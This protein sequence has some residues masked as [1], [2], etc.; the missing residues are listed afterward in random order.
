LNIHGLVGEKEARKWLDGTQKQTVAS[1]SKV[2][3]PAKK[4]RTRT[5]A[6]AEAAGEEPEAG[7]SG[8]QGQPTAE[9]K[10]L[11]NALKLQYIHLMEMD[12]VLREKLFIL[13]VNKHTR[14][15]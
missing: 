13:Q 14:L 8:G 12:E 15:F 5:A 4:P 11:E 3:T 2:R 9:Q 7:G 10:I 1:A 6:A